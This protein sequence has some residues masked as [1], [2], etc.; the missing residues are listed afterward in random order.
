MALSVDNKIMILN[1]ATATGAGESTS[2]TSDGLVTIEVN[3]NTS[4]GTGAASIE[5][6]VSNNNSTWQSVGTININLGTT[7]T[8]DKFEM[9]ATWANWAYIRA[10]VVSIS[11][12]GASIYVYKNSGVIDSFTGGRT[13][14][15]PLIALDET[16]NLIAVDEIPSKVETLGTVT[17]SGTNP[18]KITCV[19]TSSGSTARIIAGFTKTDLV[20]GGIYQFSATIDS[21]ILANPSAMTRSWLGQT[22]EN[23]NAQFP[24]DIPMVGQRYGINFTGYT[25]SNLMRLGMGTG[26]TE[27]VIAGDTIVF[28]DIALYRVSTLS[29]PILPYTQTS[30]FP[31]G[32][33]ASS[34]DTIGSCVLFC[35][36]SW[37]NNDTDI[38]GLVATTYQRERV[39]V[40]T[41]GHTLSQI[42]TA[43]NDAVASGFTY[44]N[45]PYRHVPG[46]AVIEGGI[47]DIV[48]ANTGAAM[49]TTLSTMLTKVRSMGMKPIVILPCLST[50]YASYTVGMATQNE[51]YRKLVFASGVPVVDSQEVMLNDDGSSSSYL[52]ADHV[53]PTAYGY[54][55]LAR[56]VDEKIRLV[57]SEN[58][59]TPYNVNWV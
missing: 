7:Q 47:N 49:F 4:A 38:A 23:A 32:D 14:R 9:D 31:V 12:T 8:S 42:S 20:N 25:G 10:N 3:G 26:G 34:S 13:I 39:L 33:L 40:A 54:A 41:A 18:R 50:Q 24:Q 22:V 52:S 11:G 43:L 29:D 45:S 51:A 57:E 35:G 30:I 44:L 59:F 27:N 2:M 17:S 16:P 53:H 6:Q 28:R 37:M 58:A 21:V 36:D 19:A 56:M 55:L 48:G 15:R 5:I 46:I 1:G